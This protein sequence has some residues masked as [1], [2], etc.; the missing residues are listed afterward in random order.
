MT[1][2]A[3]PIVESGGS[4][5]SLLC[6]RNQAL[7]C[8]SSCGETPLSRNGSTLQ[9]IAATCDVG[10]KGSGKGVPFMEYDYHW[11]GAP[12]NSEQ[13]REA[14]QRLRSLDGKIRGEHE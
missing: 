4:H 14:L 13:A 5:L 10:V 12:P 6:V 8:S 7:T 1:P 11:H 9:P 3:Q 2:K